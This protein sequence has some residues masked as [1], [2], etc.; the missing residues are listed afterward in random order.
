MLGTL[1]EAQADTLCASIVLL[2][3]KSG[4]SNTG[5]TLPSCQMRPS[6]I[7]IFNLMG[8]NFEVLE[9]RRDQ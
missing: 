3:A 2:R 8:W 7:D 4:K 9:T 1:N 5:D 6:I